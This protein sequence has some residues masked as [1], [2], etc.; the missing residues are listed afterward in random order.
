MF[1]ESNTLILRLSSTGHGLNR[2]KK[3]G[4]MR[5]AMGKRVAFSNENVIIV[6]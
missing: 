5:L 3:F 4:C 6:L 2:V 1:S